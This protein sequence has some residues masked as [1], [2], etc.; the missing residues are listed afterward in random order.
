M[1]ARETA[2]AVLQSVGML[3]WARSQRSR[4][5]SLRQD[6]YLRRLLPLY[7]RPIFDASKF[8]PWRAKERARHLETGRARFEADRAVIARGLRALVAP[9][10]DELPSGNGP[11]LVSLV[12][13]VLALLDDSAAPKP[14]GAPA[15]GARD[16]ALRVVLDQVF[17]QGTFPVALEYDF[18][19]DVVE[20]VRAR[21]ARGDGGHES[22]ARAILRTLALLTAGDAALDEARL[23]AAL[24]AAL[25]ASHGY[26]P[27]SAPPV[28][29]I[30]GII[31]DLWD[32]F[33]G[34]RAHDHPARFLEINREYSRRQWAM[35]GPRGPGGLSLLTGRERD[36]YVMLRTLVELRTSGALSPSDEVLVI[37]PRHIDEIVFFRKHLKLPKTVG[38]DLLDDEPNGIV[39]GNM[40][41]MPFDAGRFRLVYTNATLSY[42]YALRK[43][44]AEIARVLARPGYAVLS[45]STWRTRGVDPLGRSDP[46]G[47]DAMIGCFHRE[48]YEVLFRDD[49]PSPNLDFYQQWSQIG[50]KLV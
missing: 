15:G 26:R 6:V 46:M 18:V 21:Y 4:L 28:D 8:E 27:R 42:A 16:A 17:E 25:G 30:R 41:D 22:R 19:D 20:I 1:D 29:E 10:H 12:R 44:M 32:E 50:L 13:Q 3:G 7:A 35:S 9:G 47:A 38:L 43:V 2:K 48:R 11:E 49:G 37:G 36:R 39:G 5:I 23:P 33:I 14:S 34:L 40:H 31:P 45:D 24:A